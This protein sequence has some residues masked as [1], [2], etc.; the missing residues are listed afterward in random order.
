MID[1]RGKYVVA[2]FVLCTGIAVIVALI[3]EW[4]Q[5]RRGRSLVDARQFFYRIIGLILILIVLGMMAIGVYAV[6]FRNL[7]QFVFFWG[8]CGLLLGLLVVLAVADLWHVARHRRDHQRRLQ[9]EMSQFIAEQ[10]RAA[11]QEEQQAE[12]PPNAEE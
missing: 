11:R 5:Y 6:E 10:I 7:Q 3:V 9:A 2:L 4:I 1:A 8:S 12:N